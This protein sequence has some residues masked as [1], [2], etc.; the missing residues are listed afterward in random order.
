MCPHEPGVMTFKL[1]T[2][3]ILHIM[4]GVPV[5]NSI[6]QTGYPVTLVQQKYYT[7]GLEDQQNWQPR[8]NE[9]SKFFIDS[10]LTPFNNVSN[11]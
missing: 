5:Y 1:P 2:Y 7:P 6:S 11:L 4:H 10:L 9:S 3:Y 8:P